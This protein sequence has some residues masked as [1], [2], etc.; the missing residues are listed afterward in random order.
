MIDRVWLINI[1]KIWSVVKFWEL[2]ELLIFDIFYKLLK[3]NYFLFV[4][5]IK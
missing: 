1:V 4:F 5:K 2:F 3:V